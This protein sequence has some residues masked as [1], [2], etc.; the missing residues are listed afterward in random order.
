MKCVLEASMSGS[1]VIFSDLQQFEL[2]DK[3]QARLPGMSGAWSVLL[4][5][6]KKNTFI[7]DISEH[8]VYLYNYKGLL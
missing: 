3:E 1:F 2:S 7:E 4:S 8:N 6:F 5:S